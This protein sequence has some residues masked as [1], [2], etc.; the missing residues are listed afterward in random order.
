MAQQDQ[1]NKQLKVSEL[2]FDAIKSNLK[3]F[4]LSQT[5]FQDYNFE[6]SA[7]S[8]L[9]DVLAYVTHYNALNANIGINETFLETAQSRGSVVGHARQLSYTPRSV[10]APTAVIDLTL[11]SPPSGTITLPKYHRFRTVVD[12]FSYE[13][14]TLASYV[15]TDGI[16][17][18]IPI[19]QGRLKR[20]E[21]IFDLNTSEKFLI[22]DLNVDTDTITVN[23]R[24][25]VGSSTLTTFTQAKDII[26]VTS[27]SNMYFLNESFD[28][29]FEITF[30]DGVIGKQLTN[31]NM[32][33]L[34]YLVTE[35]AETNGANQF[36]MLDTL[37]SSS[38][39]IAVTTP[40]SGGRVRESITE[41]KYRAPLTF[42]SQNRAVTPDDYKAIILENYSNAESVSIWGGEDNDPPE[43]GKAFIS[44]KP[45]VGETVSAADQLFIINNILRPKS[46]VSITPV[47][48]DPIY[49]YVSLEVFFKYSVSDTSLSV[50]QL[51]S[52]VLSNITT[53]NDTYLERFDGILRYSSLLASIDKADKAVTNSTVRLYMKK[54]FV[55]VLN[56]NTR[57][58]LDF[59]SPIYITNSTESVIYQ[60]SV[61]TY[62]GE[63]C[64]LKDYINSIGE[65]RI[66]VIRGSGVNQITIANDVGY[67]DAP[68][69][70]I[71]LTNFNVSAF[72]GGYIE[73]AVIPNSNDVAPKRNNIVSIDMNDVVIIGSADSTGSRSAAAGLNYNLIPR[74][75]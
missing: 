14:V 2:D 61:F 31:G 74:H 60:S 27:S 65:R 66:R 26:S 12:N 6:G 18:G 55:P 17:T 39:T 11:V 4:M 38:T 29:R 40:A 67:V 41:I 10:T 73:L 69:G 51:N 70:K 49:T 8:T 34:D 47:F 21:Y 68:A 37:N 71:I 32:I 7:M 24:T 75:G 72:V 54:R 44:I 62:D 59:S 19:K 35:G 25:S 52:K 33:E 22:P 9:I 53:Y 63:Q 58:E 57:Y 42:A 5:T 3:E 64:T 28:G 45:A 50:G 43:Y 16:F 20:T 1:I 48:V 56:R 15:S 23:V 36:T 13:F 46:V 30:G